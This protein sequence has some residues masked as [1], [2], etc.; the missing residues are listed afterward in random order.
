MMILLV[1]KFYIM[2]CLD[3]I[4]KS[5]E[6]TYEKY[7]Q[8]EIIIRMRNVGFGFLLKTKKVDIIY[9]DM[10]NREISRFNVG[11][12]KGENKFEFKGN[13]LSEGISSEYKVYLRVYGSIEDNVIYY[14]IQFANEDIYN[15]NLKA[16]LLFYVKNGE[17]VE[18]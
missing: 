4:I 6:S 15:K 16:H 12:Y 5:V 10:N 7:G 18:P 11:E 8:F 13:F 14:P 9:A 2:E 17:I 3:S 1:Q